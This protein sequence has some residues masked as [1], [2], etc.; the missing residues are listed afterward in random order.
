MAESLWDWSRT[1]ATNASADASINWAEGMSPAAINNSARSMMAAIAKYL[2]D[3]SGQIVT[4]GTSTAYTAT[5]TS[6]LGS[7]AEGRMLCVEIDETCGATPTI[8]VDTLGAKKLYRYASS[9]V[10]QITTNELRVGGRYILQYDT[11]LDTAA[12]GWVVL[13]PTNVLSVATAD[14]AADAVT[15]PKMQ[16]VVTNQRVLGRTSGAG[17]DVEELAASAVLDW[18][19]STRG[20]MLYRGSGGWV[21][22]DPNTVGFVLRDGGSGADPSW[23]GGMTKLATGSVSAAATLDLTLTSGYK[24]FKL[25]L[26]NYNPATTSSSLCARFSYDGGSTYLTT[27][28]YGYSGDSVNTASTRGGFGQTNTLISFNST[29][30]TST[31]TMGMSD[32]TINPGKSSWFAGLVA[33]HQY[34][35]GTNVYAQYS[36]GYNNTTS[37]AATNIRILYSSGNITNMDYDLYGI[38]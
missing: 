12:G 13:N 29:G 27:S 16:N 36:Q 37:G 14:I 25:I 7:L 31:A 1:A 9:G 11:S 38:S 26:R 34:F 2:Y 22:L 19:D 23:V 3:Q 6:G 10:V 5:T 21:G 8:N 20:T 15:Y 17:G 28:T 24:A 4:A 18:L 32:I 30:Q 33:L 35:D